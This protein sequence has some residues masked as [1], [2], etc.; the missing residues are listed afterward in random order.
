MERLGLSTLLTFTTDGVDDDD[1]DWAEPKELESA[2]LALA[3]LIK[4]RDPSIRELLDSYPDPPDGTAVESLTN[5][6]EDI[7]AMARYAHGLGITLMAL[8]LNW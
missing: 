6:L 8:E 5:D 4:K 7:V 2:A 3:Q 1:V